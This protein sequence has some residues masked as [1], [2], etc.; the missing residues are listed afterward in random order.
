[1]IALQLP[2]RDDPEPKG[3]RRIVRT[4]W[5]NTNGYIGGK[6]WITF[7]PTYA[8]GVEESAEEWLK[9]EVRK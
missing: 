8:V 1:M 2:T 3:K 7:G 6:F 5:G 4:V 9:K